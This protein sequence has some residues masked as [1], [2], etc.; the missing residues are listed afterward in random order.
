MSQ[1]HPSD[2]QGLGKRLRASREQRGLSLEELASR[3]GCAKSYL[4]A[5]ENGHKGPPSEE[6]LGR[7]ELALGIEDRSLVNAALWAKTPA[8]VRR[9]VA[10]LSSASAATRRLGEIIR[11]GGS[12]DEAYRTGKLHGLVDA[13]TG[14]D[15]PRVVEASLPV[16]V[17]LINRVA[18][19]YPAD[20]TDLGYPARVADEYVR[21]PGLTDPDAFAARIIGDSMMPEFREGD[22]V[23][24]SPARDVASGDDC[25]VRIAPDHE[26]TFKRVYFEG[27]AGSELIRLQPINNR[28]PPRVLPREDVM[29][30]YRAVSV[31]RVV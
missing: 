5:V 23:V 22:V 24:F 1:D 10:E 15:E 30:L 19:G 25:F 28:Y 8:R 13:F 6:L 17:P 14:T 26:S 27:E 9:E 12:L 31:T 7:L 29:G 21:C 18:A 20:F 2:P 11:A 4:S 3:A 16:E